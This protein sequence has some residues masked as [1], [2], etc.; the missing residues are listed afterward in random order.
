MKRLSN[1]QI[2]V[3]QCNGKGLTDKPKNNKQKMSLM[4]DLVFVDET[5]P[6]YDSTL[7]IVK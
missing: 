5:C 7:K 6:K 1:W 3:E 2:N 4:F